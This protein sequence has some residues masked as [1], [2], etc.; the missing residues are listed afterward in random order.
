MAKKVKCLCFA[1]HYQIFAIQI[2]YVLTDSPENLECLFFWF[3]F[4]KLEYQNPYVFTAI[5]IFEMFIFFTKLF[6]KSAFDNGAHNT[7]MA[8]AMQSYQTII[9]VPSRRYFK[10]CFTNQLFKIHK[11]RQS[12]Y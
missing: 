11:N 10:K 1:F 8:V 12:A 2:A 7:I 5:I 6:K 9:I 4:K 3:C